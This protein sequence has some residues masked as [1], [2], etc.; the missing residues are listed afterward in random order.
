MFVDA[1][2]IFDPRHQQLQCT[3]TLDCKLRLSPYS[4]CLQ[5]NGS[6]NQ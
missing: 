5:T 1:G 6:I 2:L 4:D 3:F